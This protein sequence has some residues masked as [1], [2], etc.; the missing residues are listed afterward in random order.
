MGVRF[1]AILQNI[2]HILFV[3]CFLNWSFGKLHST[4]LPAKVTRVLEMKSEVVT[5]VSSNVNAK[6]DVKVDVK[7]DSKVD[8][9]KTKVPNVPSLESVV[10]VLKK[11]GVEAEGKT[12]TVV[13]EWA[14]K[15]CA[16]V[17]GILTKLYLED[18]ILSFPRV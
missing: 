5:T 12:F 18:N 10:S 1:D 4:E 6:V 2:L 13:S 7:V 16:R 17:F 8:S 9:S 14:N 15:L 11:H 3:F